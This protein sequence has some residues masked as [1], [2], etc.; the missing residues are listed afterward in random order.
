MVGASVASISYDIDGERVPSWEIC[1]NGPW[2]EV[3]KG[4]ITMTAINGERL[5]KYIVLSTEWLS[6]YKAAFQ[7]FN[8]NYLAFQLP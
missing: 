2:K 8:Q 5:S 1:C 3:A 4:V 7:Q 6:R